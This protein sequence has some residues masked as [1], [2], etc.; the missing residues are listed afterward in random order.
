M[1]D[2]SSLTLTITRFLVTIGI[3]IVRAPLPDTTFLPGILLSD[4][5][6]TVDPERMRYPGDLLHE[7]GHLAVLPPALRGRFGDAEPPEELDMGGLEVQA[8]AWAYAAAVHLGLDPAVVFH[9]GGY[10]GH[11]L[12]LLRSFSLGVYYG[13]GDLQA[14]GMS[15][16][17][18]RAAQLGVAP[19]PHM[20]RWMRE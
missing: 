19:Y 11:S 1:S 2:D 8:S 20:I 10:A 3:E 4:G 9:N 6:L 5:T 14:A 18:A 12:G 13:V 15:A 16:T 7:A 17:P